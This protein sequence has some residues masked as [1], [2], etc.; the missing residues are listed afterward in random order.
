MAKRKSR[1]AP[2]KVSAKLESRFDCPVC[3]HENVVQCKIVTRTHRGVAFC[4]VCEAHF[5]CEATSLDKP[6]DIYH[7]WVDSVRN[8]TER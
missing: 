2:R 7:S 6:I 1:K 3:N 4:N 8:N 5:G